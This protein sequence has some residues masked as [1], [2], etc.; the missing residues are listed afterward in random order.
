MCA[1]EFERIK[2]A[3][4]YTDTCHKFPEVFIFEGSTHGHQTSSMPRPEL[5]EG[6]VVVIL[7]VKVLQ[8]DILVKFR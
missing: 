8:L 4:Y 3:A 5:W 1:L 6:R 2:C 7:F